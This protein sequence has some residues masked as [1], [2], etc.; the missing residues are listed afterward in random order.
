MVKHGK[1]EK[2]A[3]RSGR[4]AAALREN[5]KRRKEQARG[6]AGAG[7]VG[8]DLAALEAGM[9]AAGPDFRRNPGSKLSGRAGRSGTGRGG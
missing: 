4:L 3:A 1:A 9:E 7:A 5:L 6:R 8:E 2:S